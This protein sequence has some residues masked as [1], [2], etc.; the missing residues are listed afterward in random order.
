ML[1]KVMHLSIASPAPGDPGIAGIRAGTYKLPMWHPGYSRV[2]SP[3]GGAPLFV[4]PRYSPG[5]PWP[6]QSGKVTKWPVQ[7]VRP[8]YAPATRPGPPGP[9]FVRPRYTPRHSR[10]TFFV[11]SRTVPAWSPPCP[12]SPGAGDAI[13]KCITMWQDKLKENYDAAWNLNM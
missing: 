5:P 3:Q 9:H 8:R 11:R 7:S 12:G 1:I 2:R 6:G 4:R 13:D 10:A